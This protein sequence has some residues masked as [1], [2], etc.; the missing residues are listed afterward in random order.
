MLNRSMFLALVV[1]AAFGCNRNRDQA[2]LHEARTQGTPTTQQAQ[3]ENQVDPEDP[4]NRTMP[5]DFNED[6]DS[7]PGTQDGRS[8]DTS[9]PND[10]TNPGDGTQGG[11]PDVGTPIDPSG[12]QPTDP[13]DDP[14]D[15]TD[16]DTTPPPQSP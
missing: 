6:V 10:S 12:G 1:A 5:E 11:S 7:T 8:N 2:T 13:D 4:Q 16:T 15:D 3:G 9:G 14:D